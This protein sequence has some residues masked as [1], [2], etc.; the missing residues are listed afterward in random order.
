MAAKSIPQPQ[1][2]ETAEQYHRR[3]LNDGFVAEDKPSNAEKQCPQPD[4]LDQ[5]RLQLLQDQ[6]IA[7]VPETSAIGNKSLQEKLAKMDPA[8]A[9]DTYW[10]V[11]RRCIDGGLLLPGRGKGGSVSRTPPPAHTAPAGLLASATRFDECRE[12]LLKQPAAGVTAINSLVIPLQ[13]LGATSSPE[14]EYALAAYNQ[15]DYLAALKKWKALAEQ[16][17]LVAQLN[18]GVIYQNGLGVTQDLSLAISCYEKAAEAGLAE[19]QYRLAM[20]LSNAFDLDEEEANDDEEYLM[21]LRMACEDIGIVEMRDLLLKAN[22]LEMSHPLSHLQLARSA[23]LQGH[24]GAQFLL[25]VD[26]K[27]GLGGVSRDSS[28]AIRRLELA[29]EGGFAQ[30]QLALAVEL[31]GDFSYGGEPLGLSV[32]IDSAV[33]WLR[34]A[35]RQAKHSAQML[36]LSIYEESESDGNEVPDWVKSKPPLYPL[37]S[38]WSHENVRFQW[39]MRAAEAGDIVAMQYAADLLTGEGVDDPTYLDTA[40]KLYVS[41]AQQGNLPAQVS[42]AICY[43]QGTWGF[44]DKDAAQY[45]YERVIEFTDPDGML[46]YHIRAEQYQLTKYYPVVQKTPNGDETCVSMQPDAP[47]VSV[48]GRELTSTTGC[49]PFPTGSRSG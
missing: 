2:G 49:W 33:K 45:W 21:W 9:T 40:Q 4:P 48:P 3:L 36:L 8:W 38:S 35:A 46:D 16:G 29:A 30:A 28:E 14:L 19:A 13:S 23:A 6:L 31:I 27:Y 22:A 32:N 10:D 25:C 44:P 20:M 15:G 7:A 43:S 5:S 37:D 39:I 34:L 11:K 47:T 17:D 26:H 12:N 1:A 42:L 41:A 18:S 24:S